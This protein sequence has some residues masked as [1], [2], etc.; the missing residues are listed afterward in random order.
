[1]DNLFGQWKSLLITKKEEEV[2]GGGWEC[3]GER[4]A[5]GLEGSIRETLDL[6]AFQ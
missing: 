2:L 5:R 4:E 6:Q 1:M 3:Y